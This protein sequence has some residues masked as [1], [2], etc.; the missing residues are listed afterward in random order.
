MGWRDMIVTS[1]PHLD[2]S[3]IPGKDNFEDF[4]DF[5]PRYT[6]KSSL[7]LSQS[8]QNSTQRKSSSISSKLSTQQDWLTAWREVAVISSG[9][10]A[11][12]V[13]L[14]SVM[15]ALGVC[16]AAFVAD[17][18]LSF[19]EAKAGVIRAMENGLSASDLG[20]RSGDD[21]ES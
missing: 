20:Q 1:H 9:L 16:D 14:P 4:E 3:T 7:S 13:R 21:K 18:W 15:A 12:D 17:D 11:D 6:K 8:S 2:G 10:T 5:E 19:Q